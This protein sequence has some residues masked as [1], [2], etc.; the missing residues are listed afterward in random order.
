MKGNKSATYF[1]QVVNCIVL[2]L[3]QRVANLERRKTKKCNI[4]FLYDL[5]SKFDKFLIPS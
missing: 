1:G 4:A 5:I 2:Q 3:H